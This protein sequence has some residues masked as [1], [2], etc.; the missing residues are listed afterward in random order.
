MTLAPK[1]QTA[2]NLQQ[3]FWQNIMVWRVGAAVFADG[4]LV[5]NFEILLQKW[6][7]Q[8]FEIKLQSK[9]C[10]G[11]LPCVVLKPAVIC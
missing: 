7:F 1:A 4:K 3:F 5:P 2:N 8:L 11:L 9:I 6:R 10:L